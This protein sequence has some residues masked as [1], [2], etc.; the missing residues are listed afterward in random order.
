VA[1]GPEHTVYHSGDTGYFPGFAE[2]GERLG[3]FD[4]TMIQVGAY[5]ALWPEV[6]MTPEEGVRAHRDLRGEVLLPIHW[7]TFNLAPHPWSDPAERTVAAA[8]ETG[9]TVTVPRPG[10]PFEPTAPPTLDYWWR[11]APAQ[12]TALPEDARETAPSNAVP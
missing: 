1:A 2:I 3:P 11:F 5:H 6:H 9:A 12:P 8:R 7:A 10:Q 4:A